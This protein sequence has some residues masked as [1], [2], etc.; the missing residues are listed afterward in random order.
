MSLA[1]RGGPHRAALGALLALLA[2]AAVYT[3]AR[4]ATLQVDYYDGFAYLHNAS[5]LAGHD[6]SRYHDIRPPLLPLVQLPVVAGARALGPAN[7]WLLRGPH[8]V[9][10]LLTIGT[11]AALFLLLRGFLDPPLALVGVALF[12]GTRLF[13]R[14]GAHV[15]TDLP[16]TG[17]LALTAALHA[18]AADT[19]QLRGYVLAGL[20]YGAA[21]SMKYTAAP[22]ALVLAV[23]EAAHA[24][25]LGPPGRRWRLTLRLDLRRWIGLCLL[26]AATVCLVVGVHALVYVRLYGEATGWLRFVL[27]ME[28]ATRGAAVGLPGESWRDNLAMAIEVMPAPLALGAIGVLAAAIRPRRPDIL[29]AAWLGIMGGLLVFAVPHNEVRL[30]LPAVPPLLYFAARAFGVVLS[31]WPLPGPP[32]TVRRM[33]VAAT[34]VAA[35]CASLATGVAQ[36]WADGDSFFRTD[37]VRRAASAAATAARG[38]GR[39]RVLGRVHTL[40]PH[41]PGPVPQDEY[42]NTFH[43][44]PFVPEYLLGRQLDRLAL[45]NG[46]LPELLPKLADQVRDG[47]TVLRLDDLLYVTN[48]FPSGPLPRPLEVW[49]FRR[50]ELSRAEGASSRFVSPDGAISATLTAGSGAGQPLLLTLDQSWGDTA[51]FLRFPRSR[52]EP[53]VTPFVLQAPLT[54]RTPVAFV[55]PRLADEVAAIV[56]IQWDVTAFG[57]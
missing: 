8:L 46:A 23:C 40:S 50:V 5:K 53:G 18:R 48:D 24:L 21:I 41:D 9:S 32:A 11:A 29:F 55:H 43:Q 57:R 51:V 47:D 1:T 45:A 36:A 3:V 13:V 20:A 49:S 2:I 25:R 19:R 15:M 54:A 4:A 26:G 10:A 17:L 16:V 39:L 38:E 28:T 27:A 31:R 30:L 7:P 22:F 35:V 6:V 52:S 34:V 42:W 12:V 44:A 14:Y 33:A 37:I 56:L